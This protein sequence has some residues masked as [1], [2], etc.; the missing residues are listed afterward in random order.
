MRGK[1][2]AGT[3]A[4]QPYH[5]VT[6]G[7]P[8]DASHWMNAKELWRVRQCQTCHTWT[9]RL[10]D[11]DDP[12]AVRICGILFLIAPD[13]PEETQRIR[14]HGGRRFKIRFKDGREVT[15]S[16]LWYVGPIPFHFRAVLPDNAHWG[17]P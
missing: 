11:R 3:R 16:N 4:P 6:C 14:G 8:E 5:C 17:E 15:T 7:E 2:P 13:D 1:K 12:N 10:K 9:T